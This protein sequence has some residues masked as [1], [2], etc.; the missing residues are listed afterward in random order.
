M[1]ER[2]AALLAVGIV[3][4]AF[5]MSLMLSAIISTALYFSIS[6]PSGLVLIG[7]VLLF[8]FLFRIFWGTSLA[9]LQSFGEA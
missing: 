6:N 9:I 5:I 2:T 7:C 4:S 3:I 8:I 1:K